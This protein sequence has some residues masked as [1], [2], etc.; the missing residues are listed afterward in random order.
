[1]GVEEKSVADSGGDL[2]KDAPRRK[3]LDH[4]RGF[5]AEGAKLEVGGGRVGGGTRP[6]KGRLPGSDELR[7]QYLTREAVL[8]VG[9]E[10]DAEGIIIGRQ[11]CI[12]VAIDEHPAS[13]P[14][15]VPPSFGSLG[16]D[17]RL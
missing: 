14:V 6:F 11:S 10:P 12:V 2:V 5:E 3:L 9:V 1:M 15:G 17:R 7:A 8:T 4:D 16:G 13:V